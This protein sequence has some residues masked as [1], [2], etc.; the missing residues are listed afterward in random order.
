MEVIDTSLPRPS[1]SSTERKEN[2]KVEIIGAFAYVDWRDE[3]AVYTCKVTSASIKQRGTEVTS[4]EG[5]HMIRKKNKHV[6]A[7]EFTQKTVTYFP[8]GLA[9]VFASLIALEIEE[10]GLKTI[11]ADDLKISKNSTWAT[12]C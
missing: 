6:K 3:K 10:C 8:R 2:P 5:K 1:S 11:S 4:V 9:I 7:I 12:T